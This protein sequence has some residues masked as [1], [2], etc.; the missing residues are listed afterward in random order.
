LRENLR[1]PFLSILTVWIGFGVGFYG[2]SL[3]LPHLFSE[4]VAADA[5]TAADMPGCAAV[6]FDFGKIAKGN[7][8]QILG[9]VYAI[10]L[11]DCWGRK[12]VQFTAYACSGILVLGLGWKD[13]LGEALTTGIAAVAL[14][15]QM[16]GSCSTWTHTPEL[17]PTNVRGAANALCNSGARFGAA[18]STFIIGDLVPLRPTAFIMS[19][20]C[21][22]SACSV[23]LVKETAGSGLDV[24]AGSDGG[25]GEASCDAESS[26]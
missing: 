9:L 16:A 19:F 8:G 18:I 21:L 17:F 2:I 23:L 25:D 1:R 22:M 4:E 14:A 5:Q 12:P 3:M 6:D 26:G 15:A 10:S 13:M 7:A 24:R 11:V 20:F